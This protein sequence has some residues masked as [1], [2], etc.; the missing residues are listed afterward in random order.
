VSEMASAA[1]P[2]PRGPSRSRRPESYRCCAREGCTRRGRS[3]GKPY[4]CSLCFFIAAHVECAERLCRD[5]GP[6]NRSSELWT[7]AVE[8][9]DA[10][11]KFMVETHRAESLVDA[12]VHQH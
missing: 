6:G 2:T 11:T 3:A 4:C 10:L 7:A 1:K 9:N 12:A 5:I 8:L